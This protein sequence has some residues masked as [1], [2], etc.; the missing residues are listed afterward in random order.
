MN[1]PITKK[2]MLDMDAVENFFEEY[3]HA[4]SIGWLQEILNGNI[5]LEIMRKAIWA[6][7]VGNTKETEKLANDMFIVKWWEK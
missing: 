7:S 3:D 2:L 4:G 6:H 1:K 5:D